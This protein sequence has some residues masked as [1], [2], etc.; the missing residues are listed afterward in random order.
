MMNSYQASSVGI[1]VAA[2]SGSRG[3]GSRRGGSGWERVV[4]VA[5][6]GGRYA[7]VFVRK[8]G[9]EPEPKLTLA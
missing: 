8:G 5:V 4:G 2:G 6:R 1:R 3:G 7:R 9:R